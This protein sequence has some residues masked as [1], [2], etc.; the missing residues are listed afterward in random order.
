LMQARLL[1]LKGIRQHFSERD[2]DFK[3]FHVDAQQSKDA[4]ALPEKTQ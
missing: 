2:Y 1:L 4:K 3:R